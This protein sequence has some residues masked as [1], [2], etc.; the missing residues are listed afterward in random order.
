MTKKLDA[1][2]DVEAETT[3]RAEKS[4]VV[5]PSTDFA[6]PPGHPDAVASLL[7]V[8]NHESDMDQLADLA[9]ETFEKI[10]DTAD[11]V[12]ERNVAAVLSAAAQMYKNALDAK[13]SKARV[14]LQSATLLLRKRAMDEKKG[15]DEADILDNE[16]TGVLS[17]DRNNV[18]DAILNQSKGQDDK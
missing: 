10:M 2:F 11:N 13:D 15:L 12:D 9:I 16:E 17:G 8:A 5:A 6:L 18:L 7:D 14:R 4:L 1:F 3:E